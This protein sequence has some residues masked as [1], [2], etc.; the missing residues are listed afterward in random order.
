MH[1]YCLKKTMTFPYGAGETMGH[2]KHGIA[3][4]PKVFC[5][6]MSRNRGR[7]GQVLGIPPNQLN[8][9]V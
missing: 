9:D 5:D 1:Y 8:M 2:R 7:I 3:L 4:S 6:I